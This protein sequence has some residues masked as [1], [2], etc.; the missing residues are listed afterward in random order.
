MDRA[1]TGKMTLSSKAKYA[2]GWTWMKV[3]GWELETEADVPPKFVLVAAPHTSGWDLPFMLA[4]SYVMDVPISWMGKRELFAAPFGWFMR[5]LGGIPI[6]RS[7]H[8]NTVQWAIE[9]LGKTDCLCLAVPAKG[10]RARA[11]FWKS[12]FYHIA[13]GAGVPMGLARLD[14]KRKRSGI[15]MFI[16]PT[17]DVGADMDKIRAFYANVTAKFPELEAI[18]RLREEEQVAASGAPVTMGDA[19]NPPAMAFAAAP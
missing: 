6:D 13:R 3:F 8:H 17:D 16:M 10:T 9:L 15:G 1:K 14:Y 11:D 7:R 19:P 18:P 5:A 2:I 4:A 12:G